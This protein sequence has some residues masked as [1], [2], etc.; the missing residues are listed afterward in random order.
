[1]PNEPLESFRGHSERNREVYDVDMRS[2][3]SRPDGS[4][5]GS[6]FVRMSSLVRRVCEHW[7]AIL[8]LSL[9]NPARPTTSV[10]CIQ[11][12]YNEYLDMQ[13][14]GFDHWPVLRRTHARGLSISR[15][16][17]LGGAHAPVSSFP[18]LDKLCNPD[19]LAPTSW[20]YYRIAHGWPDGDINA[21]ESVDENASGTPLYT[22]LYVDR[23][24]EIHSA[25]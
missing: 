5:H 24:L 21:S 1:M 18:Q 15:W 11:V 22:T 8:R 6:S 14:S 3:C 12:F 4:K 9:V 16:S 17:G 2:V 7:T 25:V 13:V 10:R 19:C 23:S 20:G